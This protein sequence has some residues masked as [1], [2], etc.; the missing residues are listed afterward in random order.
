MADIVVDSHI[1]DEVWDDLYIL[2]P[3]YEA[4]KAK[5]SKIVENGGTIPKD[6]KKEKFEK[7]VLQQ[8]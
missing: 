6:L 1:Y 4:V 5:V 7:V 8:V 3:Q 2:E